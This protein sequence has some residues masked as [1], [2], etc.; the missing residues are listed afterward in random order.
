[1]EPASADITAL[2]K[3]FANDDE[4][5]STQLASAI[6]Q[7]LHRLAARCLREERPDHTLQPTALVHEAYLKISGQRNANWQ[8]RTQFFAVA[9]QL[10]H[11]RLVDYARAH[12][13]AKRGGK[14]K[15]IGLED[16][17]LVSKDRSDEVLAVHES[18]ARLAELD[19]RQARVVELRYFGGLTMDEIAEVFGVSS[20]TIKRE[21]TIAKAWLFGD[22]TERHGN[23]DN[24]S[25]GESKG[26]V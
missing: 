25:V 22:L 19:P 4:E 26:A 20:K 10:M 12:L 18:L 21:W 8:S 7:E 16:V 13:R 5:A 23:S 15:R 1:V 2:L 17:T 3:Q 9:A 6:Y 14:A 24:R 11:R